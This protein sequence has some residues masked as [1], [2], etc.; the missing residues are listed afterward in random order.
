MARKIRQGTEL[1]LD[2]ARLLAEAERAQAE[3]REEFFAFRQYVNP[4][5]RCN[6]FTQDLTQNLQW[7]Y[8]EL[9]AV[10]RPKMVIMAPPQHGKST[11]AEDFIAWVAGNNPDFKTIYASY[12]DSLGV[13]RNS[14]LQRLF[15]SSAYQQVFSNMRVG[16]PGWT[17][18]NEL[19]EYCGHAGS[20]R[21]TTVNGQI[22]GLEIH[23]GVIDDPI[24]GRAEASSPTVRERTWA[25]LVD[26]FCT[27][28]AATSGILL[29]GTRWHVDDPLG[30]FVDRFPDA[31]LLRY[32]AIAEVSDQ[33]RKKGEALF[34]EFKPLEFLL[35]R[36]R[37]QT[38]A[39][40]ESEY[41]QNPI[42]VGGGMFPIEKLTVIL[43]FDRD[44]ILKSVRYWD[45]AGT[46]RRDGSSG[47]ATAGVLMHKM[48]NGTFVIEHVARGHWSA[49]E[50]EQ[51]IK[52][53]AA[54]DKARLKY[55]YEI[56]VEQEPGSG[57]KES[58]EAT[59]RNLI[60]YRVFA[61]R[62]T[63]SKQVRA[64]PFAAQVQA[65]NVYLIAGDYVRGFLE[66]AECFPVGRF[67]DQIDAATGAFARL[68][69]KPVFNLDA[70]AS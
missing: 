37:T 49:L 58:A 48:K 70:M 42:V 59:I 54:S 3:A 64:E 2:R 26:D 7:F 60:G 16:L 23:L 5:S 17:C 18:N 33:F 63:G 67:N 38:Q 61:D 30:R 52:M 12:S 69:S 53:L 66:E 10:K 62:V 1:L 43:V 20:F 24:K 65:G 25:W 39:G 28:L 46:E 34:P 55:N 47:A 68:T 29:I 15:G 45:K 13:A 36:K 8:D 14:N 32:P 21:N 40:W 27:R 22:T 9:V 6:W 44:Q 4:N 19:I 56:I 31:R 57:G 51:K 35:E 50:R 11:A 41:Q